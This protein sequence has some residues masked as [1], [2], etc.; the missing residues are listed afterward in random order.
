M[1]ETKGKLDLDNP[2]DVDWLYKWAI[3]AG[4]RIKDLNARN[5]SFRKKIKKEF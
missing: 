5:I 2:D 1:E 3:K 4:L